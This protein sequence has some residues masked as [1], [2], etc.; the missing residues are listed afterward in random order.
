MEVDHNPTT[1]TLLLALLVSITKAQM[2]SQCVTDGTEVQLNCSLEDL[3]DDVYVSWHFFESNWDYSDDIYGGISFIATWSDIDIQEISCDFMKDGG[4][5]FYHSVLVPGDH[6]S[7]LPI[8]PILTKG[9]NNT[10]SLTWEN[11]STTFEDDDDVYFNYTVGINITGGNQYNQTYAVEAHETPHRILYLSECQHF[12]ISISL[13]GNCEDKKIS[14]SMPIVPENFQH[15]ITNDVLFSG[16][17][18]AQQVQIRFTVSV[19]S[20]KKGVLYN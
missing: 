4:E 11:P 10:L 13:P 15:N 2:V 16:K 7:M 14:G 17:A 20:P 3:E 19:I 6:N 12:D 8:S 1:M 5:F 9:D 18:L